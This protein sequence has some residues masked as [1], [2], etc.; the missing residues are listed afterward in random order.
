M[1]TEGYLGGRVHPGAWP[2]AV[3]DLLVLSLLLAAGTAHH[4]GLAPLLADPLPL[5][6]VLGPFL[7]GWAAVAPPLGAYSPGAAESAKGAVPLALRSWIL[8]DLVGLGLRATPLFPGGVTPVFAAVTFAVVAVG[9]VA[10]RYLFF[11]LR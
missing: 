1:A 4:R 9:L 6:G 7:I 8:A 2:L 10:W 3:G 11:A 5:I